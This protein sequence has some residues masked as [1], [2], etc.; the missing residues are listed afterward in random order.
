MYKNVNL[1]SFLNAVL[2]CN[3]RDDRPGLVPV[4]FPSFSWTVKH[5]VRDVQWWLVQSSR[6]RRYEISA[7]RRGMETRSNNHDRMAVMPN[8]L[9]RW[10]NSA[11]RCGSVA[12]SAC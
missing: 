3:K 9:A 10:E 2:C 5:P 6:V 1:G 7:I 11:A 4:F 12:S 8:F